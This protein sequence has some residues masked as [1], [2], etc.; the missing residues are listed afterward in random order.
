MVRVLQVVG[1]LNPGGAE[2]WYMNVLRHLDLNRF[3]QTFCCLLDGAGS[4]E[5][6][7][8]SLGASILHCPRSAGLREFSKNFRLLLREGQFDVVHSH[9]QFFSG[10][11]LKIAHSENVPIR[12]AHARTAGDLKGNSLL[13]RI[14]RWHMRRGIRKHATCRIAVSK[15]AGEFL[16]GSRPEAGK[17]FRVLSAGI[18]SKRFRLTGNRDEFCAEFS[19]PADCVVI[20][21]VGNLRKVKNHEFLLKVAA[22]MM[23][24]SPKLRLVLVG[25]GEEREPLAALARRL[26]IADKVVFAGSRGDVHI[27]MNSLFDLV[28][29]PSKWEGLPQVVVEAQCAALP[30]V[31][32][33][34]VTSEVE[35]IASLVQWES[36]DSG[37]GHWARVALEKLSQPRFDR[38]EARRIIGESELEIS[39]HARV[40]ADVYSGLTCAT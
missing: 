37:A 19:L 2:T 5:A 40:M 10:L 26:D 1:A 31:I 14:Y 8:V 6:E 29:F 4:L 13:R 30:I 12:I 27:L 32:A 38:D 20:G 34:T 25:D 22:E 11:I 28:V 16:F 33:D 9:I 23:R 21:H 7:A 17:D 36:L 24:E 39:H 3:E 35:V 18:D 15:L